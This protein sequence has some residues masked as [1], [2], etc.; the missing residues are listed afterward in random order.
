MFIMF[1]AKAKE[2]LEEDVG[3]A[4]DDRRHSEVV[5]LAKPISVRELREQVSMFSTNVNGN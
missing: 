3:T 4:I 2:F 5:H 1:W